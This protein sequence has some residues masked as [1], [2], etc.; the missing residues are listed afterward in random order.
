MK[1]FISVLVLVCI[2]ASMFTL[3]AFAESNYVVNGVGYATWSEAKTAAKSITSGNIEIVFYDDISFD[4][5]G[6]TDG[7]FTMNG[8]G[9]SFF[10][11]NGSVTLRGAGSP[12][13]SLILTGYMPWGVYQPGGLY[14]E[15]FVLVDN[16]TSDGGWAQMALDLRGPATLTSVDFSADDFAQVESGSVVFNSCNFTNT[17]SYYGAYVSG[18]TATFNGCT[19]TGGRGIKGTTESGGDFTIVTDGCTFNVTNKAAV[20]I[21]VDTATP[22]VPTVKMGNNTYNG[23]GKV[24][25]YEDETGSTEM[26]LTV[27]ADAVKISETAL[28][29][30]SNETKQLTVNHVITHEKNDKVT[31]APV[32]W[33]SSDPSVAT[34]DANGLVTGLKRGIATITATIEGT[35]ITVSAE[36]TVDGGP[37]ANPYGVP[38]TADNSNMPL[39]AV[40]FIGFAAVALLTGKKRRA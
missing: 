20:E 32:L 6:G 16:S 15:N 9:V 10:E 2:M 4:A 3:S 27:G 13:P 23:N 31:P 11:T 37:V 19:F 30:K 28:D 5:A 14:L 22:G 34:V 33:S 40:L 1:K 26:K 24:L 17:D 39:W 7:D 36:V 29:I 8:G 38:S 35:S 25:N 12:K 18:G 21:N